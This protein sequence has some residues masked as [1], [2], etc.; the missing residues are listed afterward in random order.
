[1][2]TYLIDRGVRTF[3]KEWG[4]WEAKRKDERGKGEGESV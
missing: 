2:T 1:M 4:N 3:W